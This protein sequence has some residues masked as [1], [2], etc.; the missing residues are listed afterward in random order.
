MSEKVEP[1]I[2]S[3]D[4][5]DSESFF[6]VEAEGITIEQAAEALTLALGGESLAEDGLFVVPQSS[7]ATWVEKLIDCDP[8]DGE[9]PCSDP[10]CK[11]L[12]G[13]NVYSFLLEE[14][15]NNLE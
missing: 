14:R 9:V 7:E 6:F 10:E 15:M 3:S 11:H 8:P 13:A 1:G 4:W 12:H 5:E 2:W